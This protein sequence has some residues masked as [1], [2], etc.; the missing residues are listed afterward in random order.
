MSGNEPVATVSPEAHDDDPFRVRIDD[1]EGPLDLLL[2][3]VR[4]HERDIETVPLA[5]IT[6][7]Y[8]A[9]LEFMAAIELEPA[10]EF[11]DVAATLVRLKARALLPRKEE[12]GDPG[13]V[14]EEEAELLRQL[15]EHQVVRMA[16]RRLRDRE[17]QA[18]SVWFRGESEPRGIEAEETEVV[19]A[20]L[21]ALVAAFRAVLTD[22]EE[23][24]PFEISREEYPVEVAA[25]EIR[26]HLA[27]RRP[28][29]FT[30]L[31]RAGAARGR[32]IS[33]FLALLDLIRSG[34]AR[35][36]QEGPL[37]TILIFPGDMLPAGGDP[38]ASED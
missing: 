30:D 34:E 25:E 12:G 3:L 28:V 13:D 7:E 21:F 23:P 26:E 18:A 22:V 1:F 36:I 8:L 9:T 37:G 31:F 38:A 10:G 29:P 27:A 5:R 11:L 33:T 14:L 19:E 15:V 35:A 16:A 6:G 4:R 32:L 2:H 24:A 20:D 17:A